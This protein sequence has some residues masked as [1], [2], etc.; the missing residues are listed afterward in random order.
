[1]VGYFFLYVWHKGSQH[2]ELIFLWSVSSTL[3]RFCA[4]GQYIICSTLAVFHFVFLSLFIECVSPYTTY[5]C[6]H[7]HLIIVALF[8]CFIL[9]MS[10]F[11][12]ILAPPLLMANAQKEHW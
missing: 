4:F 10:G 6:L 9:S 12:F 2:D 8:P 3:F 7:V 11:C 5:E 1:M